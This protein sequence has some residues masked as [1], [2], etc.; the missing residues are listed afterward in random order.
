VLRGDS[1]SRTQ[2]ARFQARKR[3]VRSARANQ[4][5]EIELLP[6]D[7]SPHRPRALAM[8]VGASHVHPPAEASRHPERLNFPRLSLDDKCE[9]AQ[10]VT[11]LYNLSAT[12]S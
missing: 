7:A 4:G 11:V 8:A 10:A 5:V 3:E 6:A 9:G 1:H 2:E 12:V